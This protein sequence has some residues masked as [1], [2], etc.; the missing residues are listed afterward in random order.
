MFILYQ[1]F[2]LRNRE[3]L[4]LKLLFLKALLAVKYTEAVQPCSRKWKWNDDRNLE[5]LR[6]ISFTEGI[7]VNLERLF[8]CG[9]F[10]KLLCVAAKVRKS[11][12]RWKMENR[13]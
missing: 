13:D 9:D 3:T 2:L 5:M 7:K 4:I 8:C 11:Y 1:V 10:S 6:G 12:L